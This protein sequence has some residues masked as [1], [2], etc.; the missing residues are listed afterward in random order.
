M[1]RSYLAAWLFGLV[2]AVMTVG[3]LAVLYTADVGADILLAV[4]S[5]VTLVATP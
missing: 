5:A 2:V 1:T 4:V 3:T